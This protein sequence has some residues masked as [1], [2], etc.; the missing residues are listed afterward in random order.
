MLKPYL[1]LLCFLS[2]KWN[3]PETLGQTYRMLYLEFP[4]KATTSEFFPL[5][6]HCMPGNSKLRTEEE[7][8]SLFYA[9]RE[10]EQINVMCYS[11]LPLPNSA[12]A[13][14]V[15]WCVSHKS[16]CRWKELGGAESQRTVVAP[17]QFV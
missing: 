4:L 15:T 3:A 17:C 8:T 1:A 7:M 13:L 6:K 11:F 10:Q 12:G 9:D 5:S 14:N 16:D 2:L